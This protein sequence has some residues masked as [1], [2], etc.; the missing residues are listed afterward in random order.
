[1]CGISLTSLVA[2]EVGHVTQICVAPTHQGQGIGYELLRR[3]LTAL[4]AQGCKSVSLTV[5]SANDSAA[6]LYERMGFRLRREF[7]AHVW[8][9]RN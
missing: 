2:H 4:A 9:M 3:S 8:D 6:Q 5:T 7:A 1:M